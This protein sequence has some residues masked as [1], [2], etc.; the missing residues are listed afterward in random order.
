MGHADGLG[1][2]G[3]AGVDGDDAA[4]DR[5]GHVSAGV[6]GNN[7]Q[8]RHPHIGK[9]QGIVREVR[10]AIVDEHRLQH[11]GGTAEHLYIHPDDDAH[12]LQQNALGQGVIFRAGNGVEDAAGKADDAADG[13]G[14][15]RQNQGV[16]N[17]GQIGIAVF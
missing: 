5:L 17:A 15:Q 11:H 6:D 7:H 8:S 1:T 9:L 3:L 16:L 12:Q 10:Q 4:A 2:L 14:S 13:R